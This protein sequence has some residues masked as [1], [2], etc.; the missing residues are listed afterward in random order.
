MKDQIILRT[1]SRLMIP[2]IVLFGLYVIFHGEGGP[3]GGFQGGVILGAAVALYGIIWGR[4]AARAKINQNLWD[5]FCGIGV[6]I[7]AG[8]GLL[9]ILFGGQLLEYKIFT[10]WFLHAPVDGQTPEQARHI[11]EQHANHYGVFG[12]EMGVALTVTAVMFTLFFEISRDDPEDTETS[13]V[14]SA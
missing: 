1:I 2:F 9:C 5:A 3:G 11:A 8:I 14:R 13:G 6:A 10:D 4:E 12:V 7:Y